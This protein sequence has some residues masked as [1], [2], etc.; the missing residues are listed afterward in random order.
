MVE[1]S[2]LIS[3]C[4]REQSFGFLT[5]RRIIVRILKPSCLGGEAMKNTMGRVDLLL[6][7]LLV[8][9]VA[10]QEAH[11][12]VDVSSGSYAIQVLFASAFVASMALKSVFGNLRNSLKKFG[13]GPSAH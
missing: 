5:T 7:S 6:V 3:V 11:A 9:C 10:P 4:E 2:C 13:K 8:S 12:Y 1:G